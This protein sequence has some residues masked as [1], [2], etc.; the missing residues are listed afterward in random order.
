MMH[1]YLDFKSPAAYLAFEPLMALVDEIGA[2]VTLLPYNTTQQAV[3][4]LAGDEDKGAKH[5]RVRAKARRE[6]HL[7]YARLRQL[8]MQFRREPGSTDLALQVLVTLAPEDRRSFCATAF[9]AYWTTDADLNSA[10]ALAGILPAHCVAGEVLE[11]AQQIDLAALQ[12]QAQEQ[13]RVVDAPAIVIEGQ[14]FIGRE[15]L[16]WIRKLLLNAA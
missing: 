12:T 3:P 10:D 7:L 4:Q 13:D 11:A 6:T 2:E 16:P 9:T 14:V 15:H 5:R 8:P 1:I